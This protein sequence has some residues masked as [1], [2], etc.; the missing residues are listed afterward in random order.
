MLIASWIVLSVGMFGFLFAMIPILELQIITFILLSSYRPMMYS[1]VSVYISL[2]VFFLNIS[3][4]LFSF[5][6][7]YLLFI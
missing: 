1:L 7:F 4:I 3:F 5:F 6:R 2:F